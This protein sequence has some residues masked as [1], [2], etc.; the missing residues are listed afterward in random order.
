MRVLML[1]TATPYLP[2][3]DRARLAAAHL[4]SQ[5]SRRH[6]VALLAPETRGETPTQ[7]AWPAARAAW[8]GRMQVGRWRHPFGSTPAEGLAALGQAARRAV[9]DWA[10]DLVHAEGALLAPLAAELP[11]PVVLSY[12]ESA[13]RR[14]RQA[15]RLARGP[16]DWMRAHLEESR[17]TDWERRWLPAVGACVVASEHDRQTLAER[18][19]YERID[20]I[21]PAVDEAR[22]ELRRG[23]EPAR[24]LFAGNLAWPSHVNAAHRLAARVLPRVR[25]AVPAAELL[26]TGAGPLGTLRALAALPGVRVAGATPDLRPSLWSACV[27]L[28]P[29]EAAPAIDAAILESM[30]VGTPVVAAPR[31][32]S[33]L[34]HLLPGHHLVTA[35][36]DA[37]MAEAA[38]LLLREPVV[39]ATLVASARQVVERRHTWAAVARSWESLWA[40]T[41]DLPPLAAAA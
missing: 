26:V 7:Q 24:L 4:L 8:T 2:T 35:D 3:H 9:A 29:G 25:R 39:A 11:V 14:A 18:I 19:P 5:L 21:P 20:V 23:G 1:A 40:R 36:D 31:A 27:T 6:A 34:D 32:L 38:V 33:G 37:G 15:R 41:A 22:Y 17:E 10:P 16:Q 28:I 13:V 30:A 12:R